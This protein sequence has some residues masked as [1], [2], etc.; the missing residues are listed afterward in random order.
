[1]GFSLNTNFFEVWFFIIKVQSYNPEASGQRKK[2][3]FEGS[4]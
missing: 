1:M 4:K 3:F 2:G